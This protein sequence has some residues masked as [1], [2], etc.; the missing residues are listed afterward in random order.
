MEKEE[1]LIARK[2]ND[3]LKFKV[4]DRN[5]NQWTPK[6]YEKIIASRDFNMLAYLFYDLYSMGYPV[7]KAYLKFKDMLN[8]PELFFLK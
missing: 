8:E 4:C 6:K 1:I 5:R 3:K 2:E 7:E